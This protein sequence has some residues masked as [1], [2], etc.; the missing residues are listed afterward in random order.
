MCPP[1]EHKWNCVSSLYAY[2]ICVFHVWET[3]ANVWCEK[4]I[5]VCGRLHADSLAPFSIEVP[6]QLSSVAIIAVYW[7]GFD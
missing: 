3:L 5:S 2:I 7:F 6:R 1:D 4:R